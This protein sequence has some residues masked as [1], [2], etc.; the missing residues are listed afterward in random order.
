MGRR[1]AAQSGF[2]QTLRRKTRTQRGRSESAA[3]RRIHPIENP[4]HITAL[5]AAAGDL[6]LAVLVAILLGLD[7]GLRKGEAWALRWGHVQ[8]GKGD[9]DTSRALRI[10]E[11]ASGGGPIGPTKSGRE[12]VVAMSR[13]LRAALG[14][15][16]RQ[17]FESGPDALVLDGLDYRKFQDREWRLI[18]KAAGLA[19]M[20]ASPTRTCAT[21]TRASSSPPASRSAM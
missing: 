10:G 17:R 4:A 18:L 13:R 8:F 7:A 1:G 20:A 9:D 14:A 11:S 21:P 6:G 2:R 5:L 12:R 3:G 15:L 16:Y 19:G